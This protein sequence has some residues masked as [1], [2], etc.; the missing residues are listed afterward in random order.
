MKITQTKVRPVS[1]ALALYFFLASLDCMNLGRFGSALRYIAV[2]PLLLQLLEIRTMQLR[3]CNLLG[4]MLLFWFLA[5]TS[6]LYSVNQDRSIASVVTLTLNYMLIICMSMSQCYSPPEVTL[7][8]RAMLWSSWLAIFF[9]FVFSDRSEYGRLSMKLGAAEQDQNYVNGYYLYAFSY[10]CDKCLHEKKKIHIFMA[11]LVICVVLLTGSRGALIGY[12][13]VAVFHLT[14]FLK[15]SRNIVRDILV[16]CVVVLLS[17]VVFRFIMSQMPPSVSIRFQLNYIAEKGT[18]GRT[19]IWKYLWEHFKRDPV[20]RMIFGHGYG[21]SASVN[22]MNANPAHNL[23]LDNLITIGIL[24]LL[25]QIMMQYLIL[26]MLRKTRDWALG[27]CY[28]GMLGMCMSLSLV[29]YKPIWNVMMLTLIQINQR[30]ELLQT[31]HT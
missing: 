31:K 4:I 15:K 6:C 22:K 7:L 26:H 1:Y 13:F 28:V 17:V 24:G 23:Y 21:A 19:R 20:W 25:L 9:M 18:T 10:H 29:A 11:L 2:L 5:L 27:G 3:L 8:Q 16:L 30:T 12:I 14:I